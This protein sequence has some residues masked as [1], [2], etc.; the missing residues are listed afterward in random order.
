MKLGIIS[1]IHG[2][3]TALEQALRLLQ[4]RHHVSVIWCAGDLV[5]RGQQPDE[6]V[7]RIQHRGIPAVLGNHDEMMLTYEMDSIGQRVRRGN[8]M[9]YQPHTLN[10]LMTLPRTYRDHIDGQTVVMVHGS[11]RSNAESISINP[12]AR[13]QAVAW[14]EKAGADILIAG[15]THAP[16]QIHDPRGLIVNPGSLF[17]PTGSARSSSQTYGV[18]DVPMRRFEVFPL[19][20]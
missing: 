19:W 17:D 8:L 13:G 6:V 7:A 2:D 5:G 16:M 12:M 10:Y 3:L 1:D 18:L 4:Y 14:L 20:D 11:P 15:H 9:G